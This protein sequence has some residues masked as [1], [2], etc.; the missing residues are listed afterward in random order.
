MRATRSLGVLVIAATLAACGEATYV[1]QTPSA[2]PTPLGPVSFSTDV[3]PA[4]RASSPR[5][6]LGNGNCHVLTPAHSN[7][8]GALAM[9]S[10][11]GMSVATLYANLRAGGGTQH[12]G[13]GFDID[14]DHVDQS[15]LLTKPLGVNHG[16]SQIYAETD[17][18]YQILLAWITQ[19]APN[20]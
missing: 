14:T 19:G 20:N 15:L 1:A 2:S 18:D 13:N 17:P 10:A 12:A 9:D 8:A 6:C 4:L 11:G 5:G 7:A 16:G 3:V